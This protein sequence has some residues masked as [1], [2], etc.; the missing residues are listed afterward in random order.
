MKISHWSFGTSVGGYGVLNN[1]W[2]KHLTRAG[3]EVFMSPD[4]APMK[5]SMEW[6]ILDAE[7]K[8]IYSK[9]F[10]NCRIGIS[11][12]TPFEFKRN[13]SEIRI[14]QTMAESDRL[15]ESWVQACNGMHHILVPNEFYKRVFAES[16]VT[17]PITVIPNGLD[18]AR[19]PYY[20][21]PERDVFTFGISGYLNERKGVYEV[22]QAFASEFEPDE[23][24]R[25][26]LHTSNHFFR[27]NSD[28]YDERISLSY[29]YK[30]FEE[31]NEFYQSL[32]CFVFPSKAEGIGYPPREAMST[33]LPVILTNYSGLEDVCDEDYCYP[34]KPI[35]LVP[36]KDM[37]EQPGNWA[38]ID[39][40]ELMGTMREVYDQRITSRNKGKK[41]S[42]MIAK[43]HDWK[44]CTDKLITFLK[45]V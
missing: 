21:R 24:V 9:P 7:E 8:E 43:T 29:K 34:L 37:I 2:A 36:R 5:G 22:I 28:Y 10:E 39:V 16:G 19:Y 25:L 32:D 17:T 33:G 31:M 35:R 30:T 20:E 41:A 13:Q 12:T 42:A 40:Q 45:T 14:A 1:L 6:D 11:G 38:E 18:I 26:K 15:G 23:P 27:Y 3:V 4:F 44:V